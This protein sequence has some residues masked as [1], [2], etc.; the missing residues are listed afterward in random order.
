M[1]VRVRTGRASR[2]LIA[3]AA[4]AALGLALPG[5]A[6]DPDEGTNGLGRLPASTIEERALNAAGEA[7]SLRLSGTVL[8]SG[9]SYRLDMRLGT[10][11]GVGEVS[12]EGIAFELLRVGEDLYIKADADF[13]KHQQLDEELAERDIDP[14]ESLDDMYVKVP[15]EDPAYAQLSGF[16]DKSVLL[17]G[18]LALEGERETGERGRI[19]GTRTIRVVAAGGDG[20][21]LEVSLSGTPYPLRLE[22]GGDAGEVRMSDW[23]REFTLHA[24]KDSQIVDY[25]DEILTEEAEAGDEPGDDA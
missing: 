9:G 18:L 24:P 13:W 20:G 19:G 14:A 25:G 6:G 8:T 12:G 3:G 10:D 1:S 15:P 11:G 21:A 2:S 7:E 16:T 22:R 5:C 17:D 4:C 23:N